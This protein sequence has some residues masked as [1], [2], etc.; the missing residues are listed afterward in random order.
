MKQAE[1][2]CRP[3]RCPQI[4]LAL[5]LPCEPD[6]RK[7]QVLPNTYEDDVKEEDRTL[8]HGFSPGLLGSENITPSVCGE[9][10]FQ[11][12]ENRKQR[13]RK[14]PGTGYHHLKSCMPPVT[15]ALQ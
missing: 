13:Q 3:R 11:L 14:G 12:M 8:A 6:F 2:G 10:A 5:G 1:N 4:T 15:Y 9:Q 7:K